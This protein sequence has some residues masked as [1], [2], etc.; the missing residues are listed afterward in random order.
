M[1]S[2][3]NR[4]KTK[5][6]SKKA[7][8]NVHKTRKGAKSM[9]MRFSKQKRIRGGVEFTNDMIEEKYKSMIECKE[10]LEKAIDDLKL[11]GEPK[12]TTRNGV[13]TYYDYIEGGPKRSRGE[14]FT[15]GNLGGLMH[16]LVQNNFIG[17]TP[18]DKWL[19]KVKEAGKYYTQLELIVINF[20]KFF[21]SS[22]WSNL[23]S[24]AT[25]DMDNANEKDKQEILEAKKYV[26]RF[27][28]YHE[29]EQQIIT[30]FF[31][32]I[33]PGLTRPYSP[34]VGSK[35]YNFS[36]TADQYSGIDTRNPIQ[37]AN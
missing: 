37:P 28:K 3:V 27:N 18:R 36:D 34:K 5:K 23:Q 19:A 17:K 32:S 10:N 14:N 9:K 12:I 22:D 11:L 21:E 31:G 26:D 2:R 16:K 35:G 7:I 4:R 8:K 30:E 29:E 20:E 33:P 25:Q 6:G 15:N 24:K 1:V 13:I